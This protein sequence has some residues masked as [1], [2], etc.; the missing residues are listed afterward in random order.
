MDNV[1]YYWF[2]NVKKYYITVKKLAFTPFI[3]NDRLYTPNE[4]R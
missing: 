4:E 3:V 2:R 1:S